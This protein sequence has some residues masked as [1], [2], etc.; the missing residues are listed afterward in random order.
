[1][2][3]VMAAPLPR[4]A[5]PVPAHYA[6]PEL[7]ALYDLEFTARPDHDSY[8]SLAGRRGLRVL[9]LGCGTG[10]LALAFAAQ[11][12]A[13]TGLDPA[14]AMLE[15]ARA[16][17]GAD[18]VDWVQGDA[19]NFALGKLFDMI[20]MTGHAFQ[21]LLSDAD[22]CSALAC[23]ARHVVPGGLIAFESR[24]PAAEEWRTW[25]RAHLVERLQHPWLGPVDVHWDAQ[26]S[27]EPEIID[28]DTHYQFLDSGTH[29]VSCSRLRFAP[30]ETLERHVRAAGLE[31]ERIYGDWTREPLLPRS[32][33]YIILARHGAAR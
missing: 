27:P 29:C 13:T 17:P 3:R 2:S 16:K 20:V 30:L 4:T 14:A 25:T 18:R 7:V 12:H 33:E 1:M 23:V 10:T 26:Q 9:D 19:R 24:N 15:A 32:P 31:I 28:L 21:T 8:L 6:D 22:Q 11:G 5:E